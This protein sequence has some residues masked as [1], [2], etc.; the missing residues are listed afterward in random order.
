MTD[1]PTPE[2]ST[3]SLPGM[4]EESGLETIGGLQG[5]SEGESK[6]ARGTRLD[7]LQPWQDQSALARVGY[8]LACYKGHRWWAPAGGTVFVARECGRPLGA[9]SKCPLLLHRLAEDGE[10][11][12]FTRKERRDAIS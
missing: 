5:L 1:E 3:V 12:P 10:L 9:N 8:N 2:L 11:L 6:P 4:R 7:S